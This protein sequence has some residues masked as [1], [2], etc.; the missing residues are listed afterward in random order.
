MGG[1]IIHTLRIYGNSFEVRRASVECGKIARMQPAN[2]RVKIEENPGIQIGDTAP[3]FIVA[4][5]RMDPELG[6][7]SFN[8]YSPLPGVNERLGDVDT[9]PAAEIVNNFLFED[10][11]NEHWDV[12][13]SDLTTE[14]IN[15]RI[16]KLP[17][18]QALGL[19]SKCIFRDGTVRY[20]PMM[21]FKLGHSMGNLELLRTFLQRLALK[22][23]IVDSGTSYHFYGFDFLDHARWM[24]FMG[25]CL[26]V[27]WSDSRWIGHCLLADGGGLRIS[28]TKLKP[29]LPVICEVLR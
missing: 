23:V 14:I 10:T 20:I 25:E 27:P 9:K 19:K 5:A 28:A 17:R 4:L 22:G 26:L 13:A 18:D 21:D 11:H 8:I 29:K 15:E 16:A 7:V 1:L 24:K 12:S 2:R 6:S 3:E